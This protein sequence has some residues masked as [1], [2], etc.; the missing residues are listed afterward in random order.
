[1][2]SKL[3]QQLRSRCRPGCCRAPP[4]RSPQRRAQFYPTSVSLA[5]LVGW[6]THSQLTH[7]NPAAP[8]HPQALGAHGVFSYLHLSPA[9]PLFRSG[10]PGL[11]ARGGVQLDRR[12][13]LV[14]EGFDLA[15]RI[16]SLPDSSLV[17]K[18][19]AMMKMVVCS[20]DYLARQGHPGTP[21]DLQSST[22]ASST[23]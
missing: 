5:L 22:T 10:F 20:P 8:G 23:P 9:L 11:E 12:V 7:N 6:E 21:E 18:P 4:A 14:E 19:L 17:A 16:G 15:L 3:M 2:T 13:A 1:M